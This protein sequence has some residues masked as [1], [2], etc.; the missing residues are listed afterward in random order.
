MYF[1]PQASDF[2]D[3][4]SPVFPVLPVFTL[5]LLTLE[6]FTTLFSAYFFSVF[7]LID[8][9]AFDFDLSSLS[10]LLKLT[11]ASLFFV[12]LPLL[13]LLSFP[14]LFSDFLEDFLF[15][16]SKFYV[17]VSA[18]DRFCN[19]CDDLDPFDFV[20]KSFFES[21]LFSNDFFEFYGFFW[22][23]PLDLAWLFAVFFSDF[24]EFYGSSRSPFLILLG[25]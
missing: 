25:I 11:S 23:F 24:F 21:W 15:S 13:S 16:F 8:G 18:S 9:F 10:I 20:S 2:F 3:C 17:D 14:S 6:S 4:F 19:L 7:G 5:V 1:L 12:L 22:D